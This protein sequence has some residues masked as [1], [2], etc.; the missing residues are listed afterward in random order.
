MTR[1]PLPYHF[2]GA[3]APYPTRS[4]LKQPPSGASIINVVNLPFSAESPSMIAL[5]SP[6]LTAA[7]D[8]VTKMSPPLSSPITLGESASLSPLPALSSSSSSMSSASSTSV[9]IIAPKPVAFP[10]S[11]PTVLSTMASLSSNSLPSAGA[12]SSKSGTP[13]LVPKK[14]V[15]TKSPSILASPSPSPPPL[16][17]VLDI[18]SSTTGSNP[19]I[20]PNNI[21]VRRDS[22]T[23]RRLSSAGLPLRVTFG[24]VQI[25]PNWTHGTS[26]YGPNTPVNTPLDRRSLTPPPIGSMTLTRSASNDTVS[27]N[28]AMGPNISPLLMSSNA[29]I[30][31]SQGQGGAHQANGTTT[32]T[33]VSMV[34]GR[35]F[36]SP[37]LAVPTLAIPSSNHMS[38]RRARQRD[39]L[40]SASTAAGQLGQL[41]RS[42]VVVPSIMDAA[43]ADT[44]KAIQHQQQ[45]AAV[46]QQEDGQQQVHHQHD[47]VTQLPILSACAI[48]NTC[49]PVIPIPY[50]SVTIPLPTASSSPPSSIIA[51]VEGQVGALDTCIA[52]SIPDERSIPPTI[53]VPIR[54][55]RAAGAVS[56]T[57]PPPSASV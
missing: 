52:V 54:Q 8:S 46:I 10:A 17:V 45:Q 49:A 25:I 57:P 47:D 27:L 51:A 5:T 31:Q 12:G 26:P 55:S 4:A 38:H 33:G 18:K 24:N 43:I 32:S 15:V 7:R 16:P 40:L 41:Q 19:T 3:Q 9:G 50:D 30:G 22:V 1:P 2:P 23:Q 13:P 28:R 35:L 21:V 42:G 44:A 6:T 11:S 39:S 48:D 36:V 56:N 14:S 20:N 37:S 34:G 53:S 29:I